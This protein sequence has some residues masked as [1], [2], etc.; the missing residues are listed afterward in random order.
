[1]RPGRVNLV[2]SMPQATKASQDCLGG[3]RLSVFLLVPPPS[4][5]ASLHPGYLCL[6]TQLKQDAHGDGGSVTLSSHALNTLIMDATQ[7]RIY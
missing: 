3:P 2:G 5:T 7:V 4:L 6:P 1:M